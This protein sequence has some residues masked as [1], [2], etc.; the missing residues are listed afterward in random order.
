MFVNKFLCYPS[1]VWS[2][3]ESSLLLGLLEISLGV[4]NRVLWS[5][6]FGGVGDDTGVSLDGFLGHSDWLFL[7][8]L[9]NFLHHNWLWGL[10]WF[11]MSLLVFNLLSFV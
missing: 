9:I 11:R 4:F 5:G 10:L 7:V 1:V 8:G 2:N 6:V 3:S